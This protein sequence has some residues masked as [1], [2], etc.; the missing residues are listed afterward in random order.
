MFY[1][2]CAK[3]AEWHTQTLPKLSGSPLRIQRRI[4]AQLLFFTIQFCDTMQE[5]QSFHQ[6]LLTTFIVAPMRGFWKTVWNS[7]KEQRSTHGAA[8]CTEQRNKRKTF[9]SIKGGSN[10]APTQTKQPQTESLKETMEGSS[11]S[12]SLE[13][14]GIKKM[15]CYLQ[16]NFSKRKT[17]LNRLLAR[18][19][20]TSW[21]PDSGLI[22]KG[23]N[24]TV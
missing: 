13:V 8:F 4:K 6:Q 19:F 1:I 11:K 24:S 17:S 23:S 18:S 15:Q 22:Y 12:G 16:Q 10:K 5:L 3:L 21:V 14:N 20:F 7:F 2:A 9:T